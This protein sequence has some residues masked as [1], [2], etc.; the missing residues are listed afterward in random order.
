MCKCKNVKWNN[1]WTEINCKK[2]ENI[3]S[4]KP[5]FLPRPIKHKPFIEID[6]FESTY[7]DYK[8][9][10]IAYAFNDRHIEYKNEGSEKL[11]IG[12]Y[13]KRI[14]PYMGNMIDKLKRF[15]EWKIHLTMT[16]NFMWPEDNHDKQLMH[17]KSYRNCDCQPN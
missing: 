11:S 15:S 16:V 13:F 1:Y 10:K 7:K 3:L 4:K 9:K 2:I 6:T 14:K 12:Q 8:P 17:S 5:T